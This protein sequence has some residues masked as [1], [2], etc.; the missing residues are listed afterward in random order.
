MGQVQFRSP[1]HT[2]NVS[3]MRTVPDLPVIGRK[4]SQGEAVEQQETKDQDLPNEDADIVD[5]PHQPDLKRQASNGSL[6]GGPGGMLHS[7]RF[8]RCSRK[9]LCRIPK[10]LVGACAKMWA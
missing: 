1:S 5:E 8:P 9:S 7:R 3:H 10:K 6:L 2:S 4:K